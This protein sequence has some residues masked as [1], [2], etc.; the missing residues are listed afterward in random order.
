[1]LCTT[2]I[3]DA[4]VVNADEDEQDTQSTMMS[5]NM[6]AS[7]S[8]IMASFKSN[9]IS[10]DRVW[11]VANDVEKCRVFW[12]CVDDKNGQLVKN[13]FC[14]TTFYKGVCDKRCYCSNCSIY[15]LVGMRS[16]TQTPSCPHV[17]LRDYVLRANCNTVDTALACDFTIFLRRRFQSS[18]EVN[19]VRALSD[20]LT[21][22]VVADI[23]RCHNAKVCKQES[24]VS[25]QKSGNNFDAVLF[26]SNVQCK[27]KKLVA[28]LKNPSD[29][30]P[31]FAKVWS[32]P[33]IVLRIQEILQL[34]VDSVA[35]GLST[36]ISES[37]EGIVSIDSDGQL[38]GHGTGVYSTKRLKSSPVTF[39]VTRR[40]YVPTY[41]SVSPIP[42]KPQGDSVRW[43]DR[44]Q[45]GLDVDRDEH[46]HVRWNGSGY[47]TG[48]VPCD[49]D[50]PSAICPSC[51]IDSVRKRQIQNFKMH[52][53]I[54]CVIRTRYAAICD[55]IQGRYNVSQNHCFPHLS[56]IF[57]YNHQD[58]I[59]ALTGI[60]ALNSYIQSA[61]EMKE[62]RN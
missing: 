43:R 44:R 23:D 56:V 61:P 34:P 51:N 42:V 10:N 36:S 16:S 7:K 4:G 18:L 45:L 57:W 54:G 27:R 31:H 14:S 38:D 30:C 62:V 13:S 5:V 3:E 58:V 6:L 41:G 2:A 53:A 19:V 50:V 47:L 49:V 15:S 48:K 17:C 24:I 35:W 29:F 8:G 12:N 20:R 39:N 59:I 52:T 22:L 9:L 46:G 40:R 55:N 60:Q 32:T 37:F 11:I 26:C 1:M 33:T 28:N 25:I 21:L